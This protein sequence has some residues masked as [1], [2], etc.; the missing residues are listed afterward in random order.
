MSNGEKDGHVLIGE[1]FFRFDFIGESHNEIEQ[2]PTRNTSTLSI[3][4]PIQWTNQT[5]IY[6]IYNSKNNDNPYNKFTT[7]SKRLYLFLISLQFFT[8]VLE[9]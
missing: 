8:I 6:D 2:R 7:C 5:Y 3:R 4:T 9:L 1:T